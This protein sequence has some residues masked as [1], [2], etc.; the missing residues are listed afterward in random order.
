[1]VTSL[2]WPS[3][4]E[5]SNLFCS[6]ATR[7][8]HWCLSAFLLLGWLWFLLLL[9]TWWHSP[10]RFPLAEDGKSPAL[11]ALAVD[12]SARRLCK[13]G[14]WPTYSRFDLWS[15]SGVLR[16]ADRRDGG[17]LG[18]DV[19]GFCGPVAPVS[20]RCWPSSAGQSSRLPPPLLAEEAAGLLHPLCTEFRLSS[21]KCN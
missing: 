21:G 12:P 5:R 1:M 17:G 20:G 19:Q 18:S 6:W 11:A 2:H 3:L 4:T 10:F 7:V 14:R 13:G 15:T 16:V 8:S 9:S